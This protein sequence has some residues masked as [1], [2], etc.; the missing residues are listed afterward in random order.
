[1]RVLF[2]TNRFPGQ[3]LR[4]DQQRALQQLRHLAPRHAITLLSFA[5]APQD[6]PAAIE[7]RSLCERVVVHEDSTL[8]RLLHGLAALPGSRPLQAAMY[9]SARRRR[10]LRDLLAQADFD[11]VH[12]QLARLGDLV[13]QLAPR[14]CVLDLVDALSLNM[15]RRGDRD[16]GPLRWFARVEAERMA[17]YERRLCALATRVAICSPADRAA[18]GD[19]AAL[20]LVENGVDLAR[21]PFAP[22]ASRGEHLVFVG[23]LGYFPNVDAALWFAREVW[24]LLRTQRPSLRLRLVGARPAAAIRDLARQ[25]PGID[26]VGPVADVCPYLHEAAVALAPMRAGSGQ[27]LK[28]LEAMAAGTPVVATPVVAAGLD[29]IDTV[30][31]R[32][33]ADARSMADAIL[34]LLDDPS[35]AQTMAAAARDFVCARHDWSASADALEQLWRE[36]AA[37][38]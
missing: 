21:F 4:G 7:A 23:N 5:S 32:V 25:T 8:S 11:V 34:H 31:W 28:V 37:Q 1:M 19:V 18:I 9:A 2:V 14:P 24:P 20:R 6:H 17:R 22:P 36:A 3:A 38:P 35:S 15:A 10:V 29:A 26:L 12:V 30:H 16:H 27:Q 33:A 13:E